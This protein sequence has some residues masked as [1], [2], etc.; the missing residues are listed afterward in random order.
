M[1]SIIFEACNS[2]VETHHGIFVANGGFLGDQ[3]GMVRAVLKESMDTLTD[4]LTRH[5]STE[6]SAAI[7]MRF[8][9]LCD[10]LG[11]VRAIKDTTE[12]CLNKVENIA[13]DVDEAIETVNKISVELGP[14]L[15]S[16]AQA[17]SS[18][19]TSQD[20]IPQ[21]RTQLSSISARLT[22]ALKV[23]II[24]LISPVQFIRT[25]KLELSQ[26][27]KTICKFLDFSKN[28]LNI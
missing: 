6:I 18:S 19:R 11:A 5:I 25:S 27:I 1:N 16:I 17:V 10:D 15:D 22:E 3:E 2:I 28:T 9:E 12:L 7:S 20:S 4:T 8:D 14:K 23:A 24:S 21:M 13:E 26:K